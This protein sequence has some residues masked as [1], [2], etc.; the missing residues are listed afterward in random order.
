MKNKVLFI[1]VVDMYDKNGNGGVK[2]S[3]RN[4][5]LIENY[6]GKENV[7]LVTFPR[8]EYTIPPKGA[9]T[10]NRTQNNFEHLIAA[11]FGCKVYLPWYEKKIFSF[12]KRQKVDCLFIDSSMLGRMAKIKDRFKTI[13]FFHNVEA[14]YAYNKVKNEGL[15]FLP[16]YWAS[17]KNEKMAMKYADSVVCLNERDRRDLEKLYKRTADYVLPVTLKDQ[18]NE[19]ECKS[20]KIQDNKI[21]FV[22]AYMPQ[23]IFSIEW[24]ISN[25]MLKLPGLTLDI[26]GKGFEK[27]K[28]EYAKYKNV[29]VIGEV[30]DLGEYYYSHKIVVLPIQYGAGM[31]IK[32]AEAMMYGRKIIASDEALEGYEVD[33]IADIIRCNKPEE[34]IEAILKIN[35][36][37]DDKFGNYSKQVR[38]RFL[39]CYE[40]QNLY[41][42]FSDYMDNL[43]KK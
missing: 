20:L 34:Y 5:D 14:E 37:S 30:D 16:S 8:K 36:S 32:T 15:R 9:I 25:V 33:S 39:D 6:F 40:T 27:K 18:F 41:S 29:N 7:V 38:E 26:V 12:I 10:F 2:G 28:Q 24:F 11:L 13:V 4:L 31:K 23:N 1:T 22:G 42:R 17:K 35:N 3:Q 21:L 19:D 43:L